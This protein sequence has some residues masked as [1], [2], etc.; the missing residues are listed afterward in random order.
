MKELPMNVEEQLITLIKGV[1]DL[2]AK[3]DSIQDSIKGMPQLL[4]KHDTRLD[5]IEASL[6]RGQQ[7]FDKI[8]AAYEKLEKRVDDLEKAEGE[9]AKATISTV[10][11]YVL[12]AVVGAILSCAPMVISALGGK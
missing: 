7:K 12:V 2:S 4:Q 8:D 9:K 1:S 5:Q 11:K 6:K 3:V 10:A